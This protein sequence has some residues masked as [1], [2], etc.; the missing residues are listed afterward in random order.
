MHTG[1][2][3]QLLQR[4]DQGD[5]AAAG[6]LFALVEKDLKLIAR[7]RKRLAQANLDASTTFLV[8]EAF[9]RLVGQDVSVWN[10]GDRRK[11]FGYASTKMHEL[12]A[13]AARAQRA[14]KRGGGKQ[15]V[16]AEEGLL[17]DRGDQD[18]DVMIDLQNALTRFESFAPQD[19][20]LFRLR[21]FLGCTFDE[22][23]E[24]LQISETE[25]KRSF[26]RARLWLE[27]ALKEYAVD[28]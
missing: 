2:I 15:A 14:A 28:A 16:A 9:L 6:E 3:T 11:F 4:A 20:L 10:A 18:I 19:A 21:F 8:D 12:L 1:A 23:A 25:A 22:L 27:N 17:P 7:K 5:R 13:K 26:H 24:M